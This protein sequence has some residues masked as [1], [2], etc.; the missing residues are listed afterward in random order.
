MERIF[1]GENIGGS[2]LDNVC[3]VALKLK[4]IEREKLTDR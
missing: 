2:H 3:Y 1:N 4:D